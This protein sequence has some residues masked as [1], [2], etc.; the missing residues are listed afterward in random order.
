MADLWDCLHLPFFIL[1]IV[2]RG[3]PTGIAEFFSCSLL[4]FQWWTTPFLKTS[5]LIGY[6]F[7]MWKNWVFGLS[8]YRNSICAD[9]QTPS[10]ITLGFVQLKKGGIHIHET[11]AMER[12]PKHPSPRIWGN[13]AAVWKESSVA[14]KNNWNAFLLV[15]SCRWK[16]QESGPK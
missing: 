16:D 4:N 1:K 3:W 14:D 13:F 2:L 6:L 11:E 8:K 15:Q 10:V 5:E 7:L 12:W 9:P